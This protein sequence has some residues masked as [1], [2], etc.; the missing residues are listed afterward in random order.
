MNQ[1]ELMALIAEV[2]PNGYRK[3]PA[4]KLIRYVELLRVHLASAIDFIGV[5]GVVKDDYRYYVEFLC[6][7]M[8]RAL[9]SRGEE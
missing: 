2:F 9:T 4:M 6:A 5:D 7:R 1:K 3:S 8:R